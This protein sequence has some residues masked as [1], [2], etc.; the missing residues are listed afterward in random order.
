[1]GILDK[2]KKKDNKQS[3]AQEK[4]AKFE[5]III[6]TENVIQEIKSISVSRRVPVSELDFKLLKVDSVYRTS[7]EEEWKEIDDKNQK[8]FKDKDFML[9][10][11]LN[12]RQ[13]YKVEIFQKPP[14]YA[15]K[16]EVDMGANKTI[17]KV[18]ATIK[19][20]LEINYFSK[21]EEYIA[22]E[23]NKKKIRAHIL[24]S[25]F[26]QKMLEEISKIVSDIRVNS[27]LEEDQTFVVCKGVD[28]VA[29]I[30]DDLIFHYK[31]KV[32]KTDDQGRI[33]YSKRGY[34]LAVNEGEKIIEYIKA[35]EGTPGRNCQGRFIKVKEPTSTHNVDFTTSDSITK[36]E[37]DDKIIFVANKSGYVN[38]VDGNKYD[39][40]DHMELDDISFKTTGSIETGTDKNV[41]ISI[42]E[43]DQFKDAIGAGMS[44]ETSEIKVEGNIGSGVYIKANETN[45]G[46]QTHKTSK[47]YS[48]NATISVHRGY[49]EGE[50]IEINRLEGG[51][52][53]G[54][55]VR[56]SQ[57]VGG[58][59]IGKNIEIDELMSNS[60]LISSDTIE[61]KNLRG[62]NN[63]FIID[64]TMIKGFHEKIEKLQN[65]INK[66]DDK[67]SRAPRM[68][69]NKK[70]IID[71][72]K[73]VIEVIK[74]KV[75]ETQQ[76][77][78]TPIPSLMLKMKDFQ[79]QVNDYNDLL[80]TSKELKEKKEKLT[81]ELKQIQSSLLKAKIINHSS[82]KE[83]NE[84]KFRLLS[85]PIEVTYTT[86]DNEIA[87]EII[88]KSI[89]DNKYEI[90]RKSEFGTQ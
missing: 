78:E 85:P 38:I 31:K 42:K 71:Q 70:K 44:V 40:Q 4:K 43:S 64:P 66:I 14:G 75:T 57:V 53:V 34:I 84:I 90:A 89:G 88:L 20:S 41:K 11:D 77:G 12:I 83:F 1:M 56:V 27:I 68:L 73:E 58:E 32:K 8:N 59:I 74:A 60:T 16:I 46:G 23:I 65:K 80:K 87:K 3:E 79:N 61:I 72:N 49:V 28:P 55:K 10:P 19:K 69:E 17:T 7:K 54:D 9:N 86:N 81:E 48:K 18:V 67:L 5:S 22:H 76:M 21:M 13:Q 24:V 82:W 35:K 36:K 62:Q 51:K 6:D 45:I 33:D 2:I 39:I 63:R 29:S 15:P 37:D 52:V 50:N 25:L 47:I 30:N 26:D